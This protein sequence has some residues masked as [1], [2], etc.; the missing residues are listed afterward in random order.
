MSPGPPGIARSPH[1][2]AVRAPGDA[3]ILGLGNPLL[4]DDAVGL[5]V[6]ARVHAW[7]GSPAIA[8]RLE[9]AGGVEIMERLAGFRHAVIVDAIVT[10]GGRPGDLYLLDLEGSLGTFRT[11]PAH[12]LGLLEG[13]ELGRRLGWVMPDDLRVYAIEVEDPF[14]FREGL[15][16]SVR[17]ALP[18]ITTRIVREIGPAFAPHG[19]AAPPGA[20]GIGAGGSGAAPST[21]RATSPP[22]L[23]RS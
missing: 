21:S 17:A 14:T 20:S 16:P 10:E 8:L 1:G 23:H 7:L 2:G 22:S 11:G 12:A 3:V 19:C 9:A 18:D 6:A 5:E 4:G 13:L 15:S